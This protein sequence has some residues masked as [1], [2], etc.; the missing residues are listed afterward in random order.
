MKNL[1]LI[2]LI[3]RVCTFADVFC[4]DCKKENG[5]GPINYHISSP[6]RGMKNEL[7]NF[8]PFTLPDKKTTLTISDSLVNIWNYH[9]N[10]FIIDMELLAHEFLLNHGLSSDETISLSLPF[11]YI[12]GGFLDSTIEKTHDLLGISNAYRDVRPKDSL[13]AHMTEINGNTFSMNEDKL[14]GLKTG[15][16]N[17]I[18]QK[19]FYQDTNTSRSIFFNVKIPT[20][21]FLMDKKDDYD[22]TISYS[23]SRKTQNTFYHY[24]IAGI[25]IFA[26]PNL[27]PIPLRKNIFS[28]F[29]A[30]ERPLTEN[31]RSIIQL[32]INQKVTDVVPKFD[33]NTY[34][35]NW[36]WKIRRKNTILTFSI[37]ENLLKF[38]NSPDFGFYFS[39]SYRL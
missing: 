18:Y 39:R 19:N 38:Y 30:L 31:V 10:N 34:I 27:G 6:M 28:F 9:P 29:Y 24:F 22:M 7:Q 12:D 16:V 3:F 32:Q 14:G 13:L 20:T 17:L 15:N 36:G 5:W 33:E 35:L 11:Y 25:T 23:M 1:L 21:D 4:Y 8:V 37:I 26:N 2:I